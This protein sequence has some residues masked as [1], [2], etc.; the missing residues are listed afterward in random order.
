MAFVYKTFDF[1]G[2][3]YKAIFGREL[4]DSEATIWRMAQPF[5]VA[6]SRLYRPFYNKKEFSFFLPTQLPSYLFSSFQ[7]FFV[8]LIFLS[9]FLSIYRSSSYLSIILFS[10]FVTV[11]VEKRIFIVDIET[12]P[13]EKRPH[14]H[15]LLRRTRVLVIR[16]RRRRARVIDAA[17]VSRRRRSTAAWIIPRRIAAW[18]WRVVVSW[19]GRA[20]LTLIRLGR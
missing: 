17:S 11:S 18:R 16:S 10:F 4:A 3:N 20:R 8:F 9:I 5:K 13:S 2:Y 15:V 6:S 19:I 7:T 12:S 14:F 1:D